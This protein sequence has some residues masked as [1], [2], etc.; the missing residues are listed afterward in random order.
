[1]RA[2][3]RGT[4]VRLQTTLFMALKG[5]KWSNS[6][7]D[8]FFLGVK[9]VF[10]DTTKKPTGICTIYRYNLST[11]QFFSAVPPL[12]RSA[13]FRHIF[14]R[15]CSTALYSV[16]PDRS[17]LTVSTNAMRSNITQWYRGTCDPCYG[18]HLQSVF[19]GSLTNVYTLNAWRRY[20]ISA[21]GYG[22]W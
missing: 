4:D 22:H 7:P 9:N 13:K 10:S 18:V 1:M 11:R 16:L 8:R 6:R 14:E 15:K 19:R 20:E 2:R 12:I 17:N 3:G 21:S 5:S